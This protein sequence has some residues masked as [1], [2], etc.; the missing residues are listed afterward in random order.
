VRFTNPPY[1]G[2]SCRG[3][4]VACGR[5]GVA[6]WLTTPADS[7]EATV[8]GQHVA[9]ATAH[10]ANDSSPYGYGRFWTGFVRVADLNYTHAIPVRLRVVVRRGDASGITTRHVMLREGWG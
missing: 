9:L 1:L 10:A 3:G 5:F 8:L 2:M 6:V 4:G 7:V